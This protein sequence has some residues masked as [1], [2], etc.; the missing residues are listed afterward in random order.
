MGIYGQQIVGHD[1]TEIN[2]V[3]PSN[4]E[5]H[6]PVDSRYPIFSSI[7]GVVEQPQKPCGF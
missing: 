6:Q 4:G 3:A 2:S 7:G 5:Y 1:I